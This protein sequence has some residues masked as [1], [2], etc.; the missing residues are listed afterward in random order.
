MQ[1]SSSSSNRSRS[2]LL[3]FWGL[4]ACL[5]L[6]PRQA[7]AADEGRDFQE[8]Y[9]RAMSLYK[10]GLFRQAAKEFVAA[11]ALNPLPR[12]L[13]NLGQLLRRIGEFKEAEEAY[14]LYLRTEAELT[15]ERKGEVERYLT[16]LRVET[17]AAAKAPVLMADSARTSKGEAESPDLLALPAA[18]EA[19]AGRFMFNVSLGLS[20]PIFAA[21]LSSTA[22]QQQG[23]PF[24]FAVRPDF[25]IAVTRS[26]NGYLVFAPA[27][28]IGGSYSVILP[29]GFHFDI[30]VVVR[31]LFLFI[32]A[33]AGYALSTE[34]SSSTVNGVTMDTTTLYHYGMV[35]PEAGLKYVLKTRINLS[36]TPVSVPFLF[37]SATFA[38]GYQLLFSGGYNF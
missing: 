29:V 24:G 38:G 17:Q 31:G 32:R 35:A 16:A 20:F 26:R 21:S 27:V 37:N 3:L 34:K 11:Y 4:L 36:F 33:T 14:E 1:T 8:H 18:P 10:L 23:L 6:A 22:V 12:L 2:R 30:P 25:G 28:T 7:L 9:Q 13:Y 15:P 19:K 5:L